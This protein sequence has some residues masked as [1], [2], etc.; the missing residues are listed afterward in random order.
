MDPQVLSLATDFS[1]IEAPSIALAN[2]GVKT[3]LVSACE[4][5]E[6]LR[7]F[8]VANFGPE[9]MHADVFKRPPISSDL[10]VAGPP[11]VKF[12]HLGQRLGE[13]S[14]GRSTLEQSV[15][16]IRTGSPKAFVFENVVGLLTISGGAVFRKYYLVYRDLG[17]M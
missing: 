6:H 12:S 15:R 14:R 8:I 17:M 2:L 10:Y 7:A 3:R 4:A 1:G 16:F 11:C 13:P 9:V 5:K